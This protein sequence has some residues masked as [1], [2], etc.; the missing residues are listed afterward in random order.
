MNHL[1]SRLASWA[2]ARNLP[3]NRGELAGGV[4]GAAV[5]SP[6]HRY[7]YVLTRTW[8]AGRPH[9]AWVMLN[10]STASGATDDNTLRRICGFSRRAGAGG[11]VV[12][13]LFALRATDP[14]ALPA[15]PDPIGAHND[16]VLAEL[17]DDTTT[18]VV[19][20][21]GASWGHLHNRAATVTALF[22][23]AGRQLRCLGTTRSGHPRHPLR[24]HHETPL[25]N[26][27]TPAPVPQTS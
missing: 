10:P 27:S 15:H 5:F 16:E 17:A 26:Y 7:R 22:T 20:G 18:D 24:L 4:L 19:A 8:A 11:L 6:D 3:T 23:V 12:V 13:N 2:A 1:A 21:W 14:S 25:S 9:L